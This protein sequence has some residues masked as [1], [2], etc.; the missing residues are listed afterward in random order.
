MNKITFLGCQLHYPTSGGKAGKGKAVTSSIQ[1]RQDNRV[2]KAFKYSL[3]TPGAKGRATRKAD[4]WVKE[5]LEGEFLK[6]WP[7]IQN[8]PIYLNHNGGRSIWENTKLTTLHQSDSF[9]ACEGPVKDSRAY[10]IYPMLI[11]ELK[12]L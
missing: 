8:Q 1:V 12:L 4:V 2:I 9:L 5:Y 11:T 7:D 3:I 6:I 10:I